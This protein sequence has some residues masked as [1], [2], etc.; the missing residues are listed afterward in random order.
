M[1]R[2]LVLDIKHAR[3]LNVSNAHIEQLVREFKFEWPLELGKARFQT[4]GACASNGLCGVAVCL[5]SIAAELLR[6]SAPPTP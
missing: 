2:H 5:V 4:A 3:R 6:S 1:I